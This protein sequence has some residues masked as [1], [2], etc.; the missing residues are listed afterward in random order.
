MMIDAAPSLKAADGINGA[1]LLTY[2]VANGWTARP[3]RVEGISVLSKELESVDEPA[4]FVLPVK[5]GF[6]DE[7][8]RIADALR[9]IAGVEG[10]SE[11]SIAVDVFLT[12]VRKEA[13]SATKIADDAIQR[14]T[15]LEE[16]LTRARDAFQHA[17]DERQR[18]AEAMKLAVMGDRQDLADV[19]FYLKNRKDEASRDILEALE[20][21]R[22]D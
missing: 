13:D 16:Q 8:R 15:A 2:L 18:L 7:H 6:G 21:M 22:I 19:K 10:R 11:A 5:S 12:A 9:T 1:A 4:E 20:R 3:S 17:R 14:M